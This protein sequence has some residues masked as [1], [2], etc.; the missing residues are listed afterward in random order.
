MFLTKKMV[1]LLFL[2]QAGH[3]LAQS[4]DPAIKVALK[5]IPGLQFDVVRF[6]VKPGA[7]VKLDFTN[8]DDM[9]HNF[10]ITKP[11][12][13]LDVVNAAMQLEEKGPAM[14]YI[15][16]SSNI[17][18][19]IPIL[20]PDQTK[21]LSFKAPLQPG[22]YPYVC[23]FPGHG[24]IMYGVMYVN[25]DGKMPDLKSDPNIPPSRQEDKQMAMG[26]TDMQHMH[27]NEKPAADHPYAL[28]SPYLYRIFMDDAGPAAIAVSLPQNLSYCWDAGVCRLRYAWKGG[29]LDNAAIWKGHADAAAK[30]IGTVF[31]R[32]KT[33][34]P[35]RI[36]NP[37][38]IPV[39]EYKGYRLIDRYPEF[40]YTLNGIDVYELILP[41][42]DGKGLICKF[43][44]PNAKQEIWF[45]AGTNDEAATYEVSAGSWERE[46][47][48]LSPAQ[49]REFSITI[50]SYPLI[51][52][53]KK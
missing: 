25:A 50:T 16:K 15:P 4:N 2:L 36:G 45:A 34:Y 10:L 40:H 44:I 42:Q 23:T 3:L 46:K 39:A 12:T 1:L 52:S 9:S 13:R 17:L 8:T 20:T 29:F 49:A 5:V 35:L 14:N 30:I 7:A 31:Y 37:D 41:K 28:I 53:R 27:H 33:T 38:E 6:T 26:K 19:A 47:L 22:A 18:W 48:R 43:R 51:Y 32:D 24:F 21:S 11:G